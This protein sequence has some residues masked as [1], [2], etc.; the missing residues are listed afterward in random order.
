MRWVLRPAPPSWS[1]EE[2]IFRTPSTIVGSCVKGVP[3]NMLS[4]ATRVPQ[5][6]LVAIQ[7]YFVSFMVV[8]QLIVHDKLFFFLTV[9]E[10]P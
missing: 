2:E 8:L 5:D 4:L 10:E 9:D 7:N 6:V 3:R 1:S